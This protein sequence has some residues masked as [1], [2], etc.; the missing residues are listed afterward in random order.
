MPSSRAVIILGMHRSGTSVLTRGLQSLGI[1]LGDDFL[2][3]QPDNPTGYWENRVIV[4]INERLLAFFG[5][6]WESVGLVAA[7]QW[8][9][10][11]VETLRKESIDYLQAY[12]V[13]HPLWGFKDPRTIRLLPFWRSVFQRL[14]VDDRY[15][16]AIRNPLSVAASLRKRQG[17]TPATSHM[18]SLV[19]VVPYL[20][21]I[22]ERPFVVVDYDLFLADPLLQLARVERVL[23]F[24]LSEASNAQVESFSQHFVNP[25]LRHSFFDSHDFDIIPAV[26]PLVR[27]AYLRLR[28]LAA[29]EFAGDIRVFWTAWERLRKTVD[30]LAARSDQCPEHQFQFVDRSSFPGTHVRLFAVIGAPQTGTNLLREVLNSNEKIAMFGEILSPSPAQ[31]HWDNFLRAQP[32]PG[33]FPALDPGEMEKLLDRYFEFVLY[34]ARNYWLDADKSRCSAIGVDIKYN[35]LRELDPVSWDCTAQPFLL[36]YLRARGAVLVHSSRRNIIQWAISALIAAER[37]IWNDYED[38]VSDS[39]YKVDVERCLGYARTF[40]SDRDSFLRTIQNWEVTE[41]W[42]EDLIDEIANAD[43]DVELPDVAGP[44][45]DIATALEVP[46]Q[47]RSQ[48]DLRQSVAISYSRLLLNHEALS[49]AVKESCFSAF[50]ATL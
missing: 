4:D 37:N 44:L 45:R 5:L 26:S 46:F 47:F 12:F 14:G 15:V 35:Q 49:L 40:V 42:Y 30:A 7:E 9:S 13:K 33:G 3:T 16:V 11:E 28:E 18:L 2:A 6:R 10:P 8:Q 20:N 22:A 27:E 48:R 50:A 41:S 24:S 38:A 31:A 39:R 43:V 23:S 25:A 36:L 29:D 1:F 19:S 32:P 34:R 21:E 17:M